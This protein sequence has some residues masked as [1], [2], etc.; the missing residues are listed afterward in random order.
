MYNVN[1]MVSFVNMA[2]I[3]LRVLARRISQKKER[4]NTQ[5]FLYTTSLLSVTQ[6]LLELHPEVSLSVRKPREVIF[7]VHGRSETVSSNA[8]ASFVTN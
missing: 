5:Y 2:Y 4:H 8:S 7:R 1:L 6:V 3:M